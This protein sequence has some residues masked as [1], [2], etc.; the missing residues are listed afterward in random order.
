MNAKRALVISIDAM[1]GE[2][3]EM[4]REYPNFARILENCALATNVNAVFP[5]LTYP[6]HVAMV[7]GCYPMHSGV[8]N[9]EAFLP[10]TL[11][12]PWYFYTEQ[13]KRPTIFAAAKEAGISSGCVMW[14]CMG[15]GP[16]D[17]LVP[18]IWG[19]S[20]EDSFLEPFCSAG[21]EDFICEIWPIIGQIPCGFQQPMFDHFV[22]AAAKE[23]ILRRQPELLYVHICQVDNA[24]HYS[25]LDSQN[26]R[27]A[28]E[29]TDALLGEL[30]NALAQAGI[31][32]QT[33]IILCSDHGQQPVKLVSYPNKFL[34]EN[35]LLQMN[36][37][38]TI[39]TWQ[40]QVQSACLSAF[41]YADSDEAAERALRLISTPKNKEALG[42]C[43]I[44][45]REEATKRFH[46]NGDFSAVLLG[47]NGVFFHNGLN[48]DGLLLTVK[49]SG[50]S[51]RANHGHNPFEGEK[52][53]FLI[54]GPDAAVGVRLDG[55][56]LVDEA[57]T[58]ATLM[59]L[60]MPWAD[61]VP[62]RKMLML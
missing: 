12:R 27:Q 38:G 2:N 59:G 41:L 58:V 60:N 34:H 19:K 33:N 54:S 47:K 45:T 28:I 21:T 37:D 25:G 14:P 55:I 53:F 57:P 35:G 22:I 49:Q 3:L 6:C 43:E 7:T 31:A 48:S 30:L 9:N 10:N 51:Y 39:P 29:N 18:E 13:V 4:A 23:V 24:K 56:N 1:S 36:A 44:L 32:E 46:L 5:S 26:V 16:I 61:G 8:I 20:T 42:I 40:A 52:P 17:V 62:Q 50:V 15:N 11:V